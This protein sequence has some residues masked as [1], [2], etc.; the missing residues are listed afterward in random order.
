MQRPSILILAAG[1]GERMRSELPKVL[2]PL[3]GRPMLSYVLEKAKTLRPRRLVVVV[4]YQA[5]QVRKQFREKNI[6]WVLQKRQRGTADAVKIAAKYLK[7]IGGPLLILSGDVPL[8]SLDLLRQMMEK[9][10]SERPALAFLTTKLTDPS[11]YGRVIRNGHCEVIRIVE[12][13]DA[14]EEEK[15]IQ[16][17]NAGLY[18]GESGEIFEALEEIPC[19]HPKNEYYL[20]DLV[21][22]LLKKGKKVLGILTPESNEC[23]GINTREQLILA[24]ES[25]RKKRN[26]SWIRK[27]IL[28]KN[29]DTII[30]GPD[31]QLF[32]PLTIHQGVS[33]YGKSRVESGVEILPYSVVEDSWVKK[34]ARIGPFAHLRPGSVVGEEA[35]IGNFCEL[36]KARLGKKVKSHH[37]S[38]LG[39]AV[40]G[41]GTNVGAGTITCNYDGFKKHQTKIGKKVFIGSNT[42]IVAPRR[43]GDGAYIGAGTTLT[44]DVPKGA[45]ALTRVEQKNVRGWATKKRKR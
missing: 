45:L 25:L 30:I 24:E 18:L 37:V 36:K 2:H 31:V 21:E 13:L 4:G 32:P 12:H 28:L 23:L 3:A 26:A 22:I 9:F 44:R 40:I 27:G 1:R 5:S 17:I 38:Y 43:I 15:G 33:L 42:E 19:R 35:E 16:E 20:T 34:G 6:T 11:G 39:D 10:E 8:L 14:S 29:P 7:K 41:A